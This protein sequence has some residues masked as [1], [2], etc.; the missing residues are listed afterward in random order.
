MENSPFAN[1]PITEKK[2]GQVANAS[3]AKKEY[4]DP[5]AAHAQDL[6]DLSQR[7]GDYQDVNAATAE[8][9]T[10]LKAQSDQNAALDF[11]KW[12]ENSEQNK[13]K[14]FTTGELENPGSIPQQVGILGS[15]AYKSGVDIV[16]AVGKAVAN[17]LAPSLDGVSG[18]AVSA[19]Q[20]YKKD[21]AQLSED[22]KAILAMRPEKE[23]M[24]VS[25][26]EDQRANLPTNL[27]VLQERDRYH[28]AGKRTEDTINTLSAPVNTTRGDKF[29]EE[30]GSRAIKP[31]KQDFVDGT[32][33]LEE[34]NHIAGG[35]KMLKAV[36]GSTM[37]FMMEAAHNPG[38]ASQVFAAESADILAAALGPVGMTVSASESL[39]LAINTQ[40]AGLQ[41]FIERTGHK[42]NETELMKI[43]A[44]A[45]AAGGADLLGDFSSSGVV[46]GLKVLGKTK[47]V[48]K[49]AKA[50][51]K[52]PG[53]T[54][55][56]VATK[57]VAHV[58]ESAAT[59][60]VTESFQTAVEEDLSSLA[61]VTSTDKILKAG[62]VG[63]FVG[64]T[65]KVMAGSA[66]A[67]NITGKVTKVLAKPA[68]AAAKT[69]VTPKTDEVK[70]ARTINRVRKEKGYVEKVKAYADSGDDVVAQ[71]LDISNKESYDPVL[72]ADVLATRNSKKGTSAVDQV[73][74]FGEL[75]QAQAVVTQTLD[76]VKAARTALVEKQSTDK[77]TKPE[78]T[79]LANA[80]RLVNEYSG[81]LN[82]ITAAVNAAKPA[83]AKL[84]PV[85]AKTKLKEAVKKGDVTAINESVGDAIISG[86]SA[87]SL[88][89]DLQAIK[90][91]PNV[92]PATKEA[93]S[94]FEAYDK[95]RNVIND[96]IAK[97]PNNVNNDVLRGVDGHIGTEEHLK[98]IGMALKAG[99]VKTANAQ[100]KV[101]KKFQQGHTKKTDVLVRAT[102][103][104]KAGE[105]VDAKDQAYINGP[106]AKPRGGKPYTPQPDKAGWV[107]T[108]DFMGTEVKAI[109][110]AVATGVA[111]IQS[112]QETSDSNTP[113]IPTQESTGETGHLTDVPPIGDVAVKETPT[114]EGKKTAPV[115]A[116]KAVV[117]TTESTKAAVEPDT[118][119]AADTDTV[120]QPEGAFNA[121]LTASDKNDS[122]ESN[123]VRKFGIPVKRK[124]LKALH[125]LTVDFYS[126][127]KQAVADQNFA[128]LAELFPQS[129][130]M[131]SNKVEVLSRLERF[132]SRFTALSDVT[133]SQAT[134]KGM[135]YRYN[136]GIKYFTT[137]EGGEDLHPKVAQAIAMST[138]KWLA[139]M[140]LGTQYNTPDDIRAI[141]GLENGAYV[142][143][144]MI[145]ELK[146]LG[147]SQSA[148]TTRIG[149]AAWD[150]LDI[151]FT[152]DAP[153]DLQARI[154]ESFGMYGILMLQKMNVIDETIVDTER[155]DLLSKGELLKEVS[156]KQD[157]SE[158]LRESL[159][160]LKLGS[161][162][163]EGTKQLAESFRAAPNVVDYLLSGE[164][165]PQDYSWEAPTEESKPRKIGKSSHRTTEQQDSNLRANERTPLIASYPLLNIFNLFSKEQQQ[166]MLGHKD[167]ADVIAEKRYGVRGKNLQ[168]ERTIGALSGWL[169]EAKQRYNRGE[170]LHI[171]LP[172]TVGKTLRMTQ[173]GSINRQG[174][175]LHRAIFNPEGE[176]TSLNLKDKDAV[177]HF[178]EGVGIG[179]GIEEIKKGGPVKAVAETLERLNSPEIA[180]A[181]SSLRDLLP[182][183]DHN[184]NFDPEAG[185]PE[186]TQAIVD[187]VKGED[188]PGHA[189]M[190]LVEYARY[191]D[192]STNYATLTRKQQRAARFKTTITFEQDGTANG[193]FLGLVQMSSSV[194]NRL[195]STL[196]GG[197]AL[198]GPQDQDRNMAQY[199]QRSYG[200]DAYEL[201]GLEWASNISTFMLG[202]LQDPKMR[203]DHEAHK[204][205]LSVFGEYNGSDSTLNRKAIRKL[206]KGPSTVTAYGA[207]KSSVNATLVD[208]VHEHYLDRIQA[209]YAESDPDTAAKL[210]NQVIQ[211][212]VTIAP[213]AQKPLQALKN[214]AALEAFKLPGAFVSRVNT[215]VSNGVG[216][217]ANNALDTMYEDVRNTRNVFN[218]G[219]K[220]LTAHY[221]TMF[222]MLVDQRR[223]EAIDAGTLPVMEHG[224][225]NRPTTYQDLPSSVYDEIRGQVAVAFPTL[226][227]PFGGTIDMTNLSTRDSAVNVFGRVVSRHK[228]SAAESKKIRKQRT[229]RIQTGA[230]ATDPRV[231]ASVYPTIST[232][233]WI[234]N[235]LMGEVP[236][237]MNA[238]DGMV[239]PMKDLATTNQVLNK[240]TYD[241]ITNY[242]MAG[243]LQKSIST[244][245]GAATDLVGT[246]KLDQS[247]YD[248]MVAKELGQT[249]FFRMGIKGQATTAA[250]VHG[251]GQTIRGNMQKVTEQIRSTR[252]KLTQ[253]M[254]SVN[255]YSRSG[256]GFDTG[257]AEV[258]NEK[259]ALGANIDTNTES[260][261]DAAMAGLQENSTAI[262]DAMSALISHGSDTQGTSEHR[263]DAIR[264]QI[265]RENALSIFDLLANRGPKQ[266]NPGHVE[267]LR[268]LLST[269]VTKVLNPT[270]LFIK[271]NAARTGGSFES[272][273]ENPG[274]G[275][276]NLDI[277][278]ESIPG[279]SGLT[280]Q[281]TYAHELFHAITAA[282]TKMDS[283]A[284]RDLQKLYDIVA[285]QVDPAALY[286]GDMDYAEE[287]HD[288][289]FGSSATSTQATGTHGQKLN[290]PKQ[291]SHHLDE[292]LA[293]GLTHPQLSLALKRIAITPDNRKLF[294]KASWTDII[295][296]NLQETI[297]KFFGRLTDIVRGKFNADATSGSAYD[298]LLHLT[299]QLAG[300]DSKHKSA[301]YSKLQG[302][303]TYLNAVGDAFNPVIKSG[304]RKIFNTKVTIGGKEYG[305]FVDAYQHSKE[306]IDD[307]S[308]NWGQ[309]L[310][311]LR[312]RIDDSKFGFMRTMLREMRGLTD[313][314]SEIHRLLNLRNGTLERVKQQHA[315]AMTAELDNLWSEPLRDDEKEG[316]FYG[317]LKTD[318]QALSTN[319]STQNIANILRSSS[320]RT[321]AIQRITCEIG[322]D[323]VTGQYKNF[324]TKQARS[325]GYFLVHGRALESTSFLSTRAIAAMDTFNLEADLSSADISKAEGL[326]NTLATLYALDYT[327]PIHLARVE[328]LATTQEE[329]FARLLSIH[330]DL[331]QESARRL[332]PKNS[333]KRM[334]GYVYDLTNPDILVT[335]GTQ[336]NE[337][338]LLK[339]EYTRA[340]GSIAKDPADLDRQ[341]IYL[342][343]AQYGVRNSLQAG[344]MSYTSN[345][346]KGTT[347]SNTDTAFIEKKLAA[348]T[349]EWDA[350]MAAI[351]P[352]VGPEVNYAIPVLADNGTILSYRYMMSEGT[353]N[354]VLGRLP[355]YDLSLSRMA[356]QLIDKEGTATF[357]KDVVQA[358]KD[359]HGAEGFT[360]HANFVRVAPDSP[361]PDLQGAYWMMPPA[362]RADVRDIWGE[363]GMWV[364][365]DVVDLI[366]GQRKVS[367]TNAFNTPE[368]ERKFRHK[369]F[370]DATRIL[371]GDKAAHRARDIERL[372]EGM[373]VYARK[374]IVVRTLEVTADNHMSNNVYLLARGVEPLEIAK[375][376]N[377]ALRGITDYQRDTRELIRLEREL[378]IEQDKATPNPVRVKNLHKMVQVV[379]N[380]L[381]VNP[382]TEF[383]DA[384]ALQSIVEDMDVSTTKDPFPGIVK[385]TVDDTL[386]RLPTPIRNVGK[387]M[388]MAEDTQI[389]RL[390]NNAVQMTDF[391]SRYVL[392]KHY[393]VKEAVA[394]DAA[395]VKVMDEFINFNIPTHRYVDWANRM[396]LAWFT[397]YF[398]RVQKQ[399][400][401][402]TA[403]KPFQAFLAYT[404]AHGLG[405]ANI[406]EAVP[407]VRKDL[408][409][410][411]QSPLHQA[412][413]S[414]HNILTM[415][416]AGRLLD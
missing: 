411:A 18:D 35:T 54:V 181:L 251:A 31:F 50:A 151:T 237:V 404:L 159:S 110:A 72:A 177:N 78:Q 157:P 294:A 11:A 191:Q 1:I 384:G 252:S 297:V 125:K 164:R 76:G 254:T 81:A 194:T 119:V 196:R 340:S 128:G 342:Y 182:G 57:P 89:S 214:R 173:K 308:D 183:L 278:A 12:D 390:M 399:I 71:H 90:A 19:Y 347:L 139:T 68:L 222:R 356:G 66:K 224:T 405:I 233:A 281:T 142:S 398:M 188:D 397:R 156:I 287:L 51:G 86:S 169:K 123:M 305:R 236:H 310:R 323:P 247:A 166:D 43:N 289:I 74:N 261:V 212:M 406:T 160:F 136:D 244:A 146:E 326:I 227:T 55:T 330:R 7:I 226:T 143:D 387:V 105:A 84:T 235:M 403:D 296:N 205:L 162:F 47:V 364:A 335:T 141:L 280:A 46:S 116:E 45:M 202:L 106:L 208:S 172:A 179:L 133:F 153:A 65:A 362:T 70:Q 348:F 302:A 107:S 158:T 239:V 5:A 298:Q 238:H 250:K 394:H 269:V 39:A 16:S 376:N 103:A 49:V 97:S 307:D 317:A 309:Y 185:D 206:M 15:Q 79:Q 221:N 338:D 336:E 200:F 361:D 161:A 349:K 170:A 402:S 306:A 126:T 218:T 111:L 134:E 365:K 292:F 148:I 113:P 284:L 85:E 104:I 400:K 9:N 210:L 187:A 130:P 256:G 193:I 412:M 87:S 112:S 332:F 201:T 242:D 88:G 44:W 409:Q 61:P 299:K 207:G 135:P 69:A 300:V 354:K 327:D 373:S 120:V 163:T 331:E 359:M 33:L 59:E 241:V 273:I 268:S 138:F 150:A 6:Q 4:F 401:N 94:N 264:E 248:A 24:G 265:S 8:H 322:A 369:V 215:L 32:K 344:A 99:D 370:V 174:N 198:F 213:K 21:P 34:G 346:R 325:L 77:L 52:V 197:G 127:L 266:D 253:A 255:Q 329:G 395:V 257:N 96:K 36:L 175:K 192:F 82:K 286:D 228:V 259:G 23:V 295:G 372:F 328:H 371:F 341:P 14:W 165:D 64:G 271:Y 67:A 291:L 396:G 22:D 385:K 379:N 270:D 154:V 167:E 124:A 216:E 10:Q 357:N 180:M 415:A 80:N 190:A 122:K 75:K 231:T 3:R 41:K 209:V 28:K 243:E 318:L 267:H 155:F 301:V 2:A 315:E 20:K 219:Y 168:V 100:L 377:E 382:T 117:D 195:L 220:Y 303:T 37:N 48:Q 211:E 355:H 383:I 109:D 145:Q 353:K 337:Q 388:T 391:I 352:E 375:Y 272:T 246:L 363:D 285:S 414:P 320:E 408:A 416:V 25:L 129:D 304:L 189:L 171:F 277:A 334:K 313:R 95:Q 389:Y 343:T 319:M 13:G 345:K 40:Q 283:R 38:A 367:V 144:K 149:K 366:Y 260:T 393:T 358:L 73:K 58:A 60:A 234:A 132:M 321:A 176:A 17:T 413:E 83:V 324:Y 360:R 276:I 311:G 314:V 115:V 225:G 178:I 186:I 203:P 339:Q 333:C 230:L 381:A 114:P 290:T 258:T 282:A 378:R 92:S 137:E 91:N 102:A 368:Q 62:A 93:I 240:L 121:D 293:H 217:A 312:Y 56:K 410:L 42:P 274:I 29:V 98:L 204:L 407:I 147:I 288:Y 262:N 275:H 374:N 152:K 184:L 263:D 140:S 392:Y 279:A 316:L 63:G 101:L 199:A 350:P 30:A 108:L 53:S 27:E 26:T 131:D 351:D 380:Q 229:G 223:Q 386:D 249:F 118:E 232:E 245:L